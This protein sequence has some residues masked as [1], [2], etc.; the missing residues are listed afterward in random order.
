[1]LESVGSSDVVMDRLVEE[2]RFCI[3]DINDLSG[4]KKVLVD[5]GF[6]DVL[7]VTTRWLKDTGQANTH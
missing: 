5:D 2:E 4:M 6:P 7:S 1:L 3:A